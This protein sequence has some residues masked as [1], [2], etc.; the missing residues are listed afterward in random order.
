MVEEEYAPEYLQYSEPV[1]QNGSVFSVSS[2]ANPFGEEVASSVG[3]VVTVLL[4]ESMSATKKSAS[5]SNKSTE[6]SS[7][8]LSLLGSVI[9]TKG[10]GGV[11]LSM[12][13]GSDSGFSGSGTSSQSNAID[14]T[15]T[16]TVNKV[17]PNGN[18]YIK[19]EKWIR[20]NTGEELVQLSGVIRPDDILSGNRIESTKIADARIIY[21]GEGFIKDSTEPGL[22]FKLFNN[23]WWPL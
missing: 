20:I 5:K 12:D 8:P 1:R 19:G 17:L 7:A 10:L 4:M 15:L 2:K 6:V 16:V 14:G 23:S 11:D 22:L 9:T 3:D 13:M 21:S 18:L